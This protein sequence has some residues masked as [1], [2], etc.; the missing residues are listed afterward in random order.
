M[1]VKICG[2]T[3]REDV[4]RAVAL[5]AWAVGV[6]FYR[7][8]PRYVT[9]VQARAILSAVPAGVV[10]VGVFVGASAEE[11]EAVRRDS[12]ITHFQFHGDENPAL[13]AQFKDRAIR[14]V[15]PR[16]AAEVDALAAYSGALALLVDAFVPGQA[17][18]TGR[19]ADWEL[20]RRAKR[21]GRVVLAGG[22]TAANVAEA[23]REVAP[24]AVDVA[25]GVEV[26]PGVKDAAKLDAFFQAVRATE[27]EHS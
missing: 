22:L 1:N 16:S 18:G 24:F 27:K 15:S 3:R 14:A 26:S 10:T 9:P 2:V 19:L 17:G 23:I 20:A 11:I 5:G 8:S 21:H 6:N 25:S 12:G 7:K 13:V 4:D